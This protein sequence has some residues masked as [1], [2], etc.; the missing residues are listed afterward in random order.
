[1]RLRA[2][3]EVLVYTCA[4]CSAPSVVVY[5]KQTE[6]EKMANPYATEFQKWKAEQDKFQLQELL[7]YNLTALDSSDFYNVAM[8]EQNDI[9]YTQI[10]VAGSN[11]IDLIERQVS[12]NGTAHYQLS[13]EIYRNNDTSSMQH[14]INL[15]K[16][17]DYLVF[18][19]ESDPRLHIVA[20]CDPYSYFNN[21]TY[22]CDPCEKSTRTFG[23]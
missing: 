13:K 10:F 6:R 4:D 11:S 12:K 2:G 18:K 15:G 23:V 7:N 20:V 9:G 3:K 8:Y 5:D 19:E 1:M 16:S 17:H 22:T 21:K 14:T